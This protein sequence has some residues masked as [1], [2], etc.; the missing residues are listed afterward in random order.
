MAKLSTVE[1]CAI[2]GA[3][4]Q[5]KTVPEIAK[6]LNRTEKVVSNYID[7]LGESLIKVEEV[8]AQ[9]ARGK[10]VGQVEVVYGEAQEVR[11]ISKPKT[12][13]EL[14]REENELLKQQLEESQAVNAG[15]SADKVDKENPFGI[16][17]IKRNIG[18]KEVAVGAIGSEAASQ[19]VDELAKRSRPSTS[20]GN[21]VAPIKRKRT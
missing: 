13:A 3:M 6:M 19:R 12:E 10:K 8:R 2:Q 11:Q 7:D 15:K 16:Q 4:A 1:K 14:L 17:A 21:Y 18:G 9:L 5:D 20:F